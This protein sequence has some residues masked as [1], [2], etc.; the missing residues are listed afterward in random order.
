MCA[1]TQ[2]LSLKCRRILTNGILVFVSHPPHR[3]CLKRTD[4]QG[5]VSAQSHA[6]RAQIC[7]QWKITPNQINSYGMACLVLFQFKNS[8]QCYL[9]CGAW[10]SYGW[11]TN[12]Y[13]SFFFFFL[14][15]LNRSFA[16]DVTVAILMDLSEEVFAI[17][18][19]P[20]ETSHE[21]SF[22]ADI[23]FCFVKTLTTCHVSAI[24]L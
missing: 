20:L 15:T 14:S 4:G 1:G 23:S 10:F 9:S 22:H 12:Q 8:L 13:Y 21:F 11:P 19:Y 2:S 16:R 18:K 6:V 17:L 5:S 24:H 7:S 3:F